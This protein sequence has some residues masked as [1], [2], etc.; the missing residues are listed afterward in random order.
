MKDCCNEL[1]SLTLIYL[2][3]VIFT[4]LKLG[5]YLQTKFN[6]VFPSSVSPRYAGAAMWAL[7]DPLNTF[8]CSS[9]GSSKIWTRFYPS[10][11][12][13]FKVQATGYGLSPNPHLWPKIE[14]SC[15]LQAH[16]PWFPLAI[17]AILNFVFPMLLVYFLLYTVCFSTSSVRGSFYNTLL[18][19]HF[20]LSDLNFCGYKII[21][22]CEPNL[23]FPDSW[24]ENYCLNN[25]LIP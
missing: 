20:V 2:C 23:H 8:N 1:D 6:C 5:E 9:E 12:P 13:T 21:L 25:S 17:N 3:P 16:S 15:K 14:T 4:F 22:Y 19:E 18:C 10:R 11:L 24:W 7:W